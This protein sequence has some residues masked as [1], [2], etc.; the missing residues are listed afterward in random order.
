MFILGSPMLKILRELL[1][2]SLVDFASNGFVTTVV[3]STYYSIRQVPT[4]ETARAAVEELI[5]ANS[6]RLKKNLDFTESMIS[7]IVNILKKDTA[8]AA[9]EA[10]QLFQKE[11]SKAIETADMVKRN[12]IS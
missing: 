1:R 7:P 5:K 10:T 8:T 4:S 3:D 12:K 11:L 9:E 6:D 2:T